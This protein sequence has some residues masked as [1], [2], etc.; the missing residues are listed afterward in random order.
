MLASRAARAAAA[1][2][3]TATVVLTAFAPAASA[4]PP[5]ASR[6]GRPGHPLPPGA[7]TQLQSDL[8][9]AI[10][11]ATGQGVTI[12]LLSTGVDTSVVGL[13]SH[14]TNGPDYIFRP[15]V[16]LSH[17]YG[18]LMATLLA[19]VPGEPGL[20]AGAR[21][22]SLRVE[23]D[24]AEPGYQSFYNDPASDPQQPIAQA[25]R[26]AVGHGAEVI[27]IDT[28]FQTPEPAMLDAVRYALS[29][30]VVVVAPEDSQLSAPGPE[31]VYPAGVAGVI[32]VSA[33]T[34]PGWLAPY[35]SNPM[36]A[37]NSV[38]ISAPGNSEEIPP[39]FYQID[40]SAVAVP[41]VAAT[42][43]LI[44]ERQPRMSPS[45]VARAIAMSARD[46]PSGG[47]SLS[48]GFGVLDPY[49]AVLDAGKVAGLT[50]TAPAGA[51]GTVAA[52]ARFGDGQPPGV[53]SAL[54]PARPWYLVSGPL[55][56]VGAVAL[57]AAAVLA[58]RRRRPRRPND[59]RPAISTHNQP[60][61]PK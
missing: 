60:V 35:S 33:T 7:W 14:V 8:N 27:A 47:Y 26:Y 42:A 41:F 25:I 6:P 37:N 30:N 9:A 17:T 20:A 16:P 52:S 43:A 40:G 18:T 44:K 34:F 5:A 12:A 55:V 56:A 58:A 23:P 38:L 45:L 4:A 49:D 2:L 24:P 19:G 61:L 22:L 39:D 21:I 57:A 13:A 31:Y 48:G 10:G 54:P 46:R 28:S 11:E 36:E 32:G 1:A 50:A 29:R 53:I 59:P 51:P 3:V 15:Q